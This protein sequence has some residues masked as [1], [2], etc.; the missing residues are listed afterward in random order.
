VHPAPPGDFGYAV[1]DG[2]AVRGDYGGEDAL[3]A[4]VDEAHAL[5]IRVLLDLVP[6]HTSAQH[7]YFIQA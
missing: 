7:R 3:R 1:T 6:N 4:L 5:G 2:L